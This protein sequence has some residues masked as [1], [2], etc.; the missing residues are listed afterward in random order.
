MEIKE[1]TE[2][3]GMIGREERKWDTRQKEIKFLSCIFYKNFKLSLST[4][5][6]NVRKVVIQY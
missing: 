3:D 6:L 1:E 5:I 2:E 4:L